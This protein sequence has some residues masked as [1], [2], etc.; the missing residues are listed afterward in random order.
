[1]DVWWRI[2]RQSFSE[3]SQG[4][5]SLEWQVLFSELTKVFRVTLCYEVRLELEGWSV[6]CPK[7]VSWP[8]S[9]NGNNKMK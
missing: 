2:G 9:L 3:N 4:N 5:I 7:V 1:M 6:V 8:T